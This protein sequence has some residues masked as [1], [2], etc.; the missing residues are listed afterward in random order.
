M[1]ACLFAFINSIYNRIQSQ[2]VWKQKKNIIINSNKF[3]YSIVFLRYGAGKW[4]ESN[5]LLLVL[6]LL[7]LF[8]V[9]L[10]AAAAAGA[11]GSGGGLCVFIYNI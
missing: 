7:L 1:L 2:F 3:H 10:C 6:L 8:V 5:F 4:L 11:G 9:Y